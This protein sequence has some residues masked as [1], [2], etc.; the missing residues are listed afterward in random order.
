M[1]MDTTRLIS[2]LSYWY[3]EMDNCQ[4][5]FQDLNEM[6]TYRIDKNLNKRLVSYSNRYCQESWAAYDTQVI[7]S[8]LRILRNDRILYQITPKTSVFFK[9]K[10]PDS[11]WISSESLRPDSAIDLARF[12]RNMAPE[13][14]IGTY[15]PTNYELR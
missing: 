12:C 6:K 11:T 14:R 5:D 2:V 13:F 3:F 8:C 10:Q 7:Q 15:L 4:T 9:K 1:T